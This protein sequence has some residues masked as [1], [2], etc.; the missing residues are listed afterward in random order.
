MPLIRRLGSAALVLVASA[1]AASPPLLLAQNPAAPPAPAERTRTPEVKKLTLVGVSKNV[2]EAELL[3]SISTTPTHCKSVVFIPFCK[4]TPATLFKDR[5]YL[6]HRELARDVLRIRIWYYQ[7]GYREATADTTV[8]WLD[9][10]DVAVTFT[11]VEGLPTVVT[12]VA[13]R[14]DSTLLSRKQ[15]DELMLVKR[16]ERLDLFKLDSSRAFFQNELWEQGYADALI[17]TASIVD[18]A[19]HTARVQVQLVANH[20]T[21][22]GAINIRGTSQ[23]TPTVVRNSLSF[24]EGDLFRRSAVLESQR[25]LYE[26]NLFRLAVITVPET[27]DSVKTVNVQVREA[28]LHEARVSGGFN[29]VSFLQTEARYTAFNLLGGA[30]RLDAQVLLGNL[31]ARTLNG[32]DPFH[33]FNLDAQKSVTGNGADFLQPTYNASVRLQQPAFLQRPRN[34]F[35][36]GVFTQRRSVPGVV[37]DRGYGADATFTRS[38]A[39]RTPA[40]LTYRFEQT[41]VEANGPYFCINFGVCEPATI[42]ALRSHNRL[43]PL[44]LTAFSDRSDHPLAPTRGYTA[45]ATAEYASAATAS[46]YTYKRGFAE[47]ALYTRLG[48]PTS[49]LAFHLRVGIVQPG[50][51]GILHPRNRFYAGGASS[52]RGFGENQLGPRVLTVPNAL[53]VHAMDVNGA[54]CDA[55]SEAVRFCDPNTATDS[56]PP[57]RT[58]GSSNFTPRPTGGTSLLEG[59]VEYRFRLPFFSLGGAVFVDGASVGEKVLDPLNGGLSSLAGLVKGKTA[60]TPGFGV[61][62]YSPVGAIRVDMGYNPARVE[63]LLV[64]TEIQRNG[65]AEIVPLE[66]LRRYDPLEGQ[67]GWRAALNRLTLH[68]SIGEAY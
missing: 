1:F 62:Y 37:I 53:L 40:S 68:L 46:D 34:T 32:V 20:L 38:L 65:R 17:D 51:D 19:T 47:G 59:S 60:I 49:V 16:G 48:A 26:S 36:V 4:L 27:F 67:T 66:T 42:D 33:A 12:D 43:S 55:R 41:R 50:G 64:V 18:P 45:R 29:T 9:D 7:H 21:Q 2:N 8:T 5:R 52:V 63:N 57:F 25:N 30:R 28:P 31:F 61:R 11:I 44:T 13:V 54:P 56:T 6:D 22:V 15:V 39:P 58:A 23:V 35:G 14:Y 24:R 3:A 10:D